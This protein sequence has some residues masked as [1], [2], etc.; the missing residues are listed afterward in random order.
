M[1]SFFFSLVWEDLKKNVLDDILYIDHL[2]DHCVSNVKVMGLILRKCKSL[3][4][5]ASA[6][7]VNVNQACYIFN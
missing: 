1:N 5:K 6:K 7:C 3:W 4:T 2:V